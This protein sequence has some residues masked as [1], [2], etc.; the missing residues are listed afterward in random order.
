MKILYR[1]SSSLLALAVLTAGMPRGSFAANVGNPSYVGIKVYEARASANTNCSNSI[2]IFADSSPSYKDMAGTPTFGNG[3]VPNGTY[4]CLAIKM[5]DR[6][7]ARPAFTSDAGNCTP[8]TL[9]VLDVARGDLTQDPVTGVQT[10][11]TNGGEDIVWLYISTT[12]SDNV[13]APW[14]PATPFRLQNP[15][16][17]SNDKVGTFVTDFAGKVRDQFGSCDCDAPTFSF[18]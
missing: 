3:T 2:R 10:A 9:V 16:V 8:S 5:S 4:P 1:F 12:G 14:T 17:V 7:E 13:N 6:I 18:R 15:F 11:T